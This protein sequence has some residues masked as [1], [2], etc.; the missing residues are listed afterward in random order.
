MIVGRTEELAQLEGLVGELQTGRGGVLALHGEAGIGKTAL[1]QALGER[2]A[3]EV[4][5]LRAGGVEAEAELAFS[6]LAD[7]LVPVTAELA[8]LPVPQAAALGA[9]LAK[10]SRLGDGQ[11]REFRRDRNQQIG[12][13]RE[14][15]FGLGLDATGPQ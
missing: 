15:E 8:A 1:L 5:L 13:G 7:L 11:R 6:A 12:Q 4:T 2:C 10:R 3:S 9:A 14:R